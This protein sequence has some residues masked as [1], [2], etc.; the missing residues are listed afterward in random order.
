VLLWHQPQPS[1]KLTAI[2]EARLVAN[3][4]DQRRSGNRSDPLDL[5]DFVD[6]PD[7]IARVK[8]IP[9]R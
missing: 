9:L 5:E 8:D 7:I 4:G 6:D 3:C 1:R 2:F